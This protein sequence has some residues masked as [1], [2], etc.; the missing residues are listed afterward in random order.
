MK[1]WISFTMMM[2][3]VFV[4][5]LPAMAVENGQKTL[6]DVNAIYNAETNSV[7]A[8]ANLIYDDGDHVV[9]Y[10]NFGTAPITFYDEDGVV[11]YGAAD[12]VSVSMY[13]SYWRAAGIYNPILVVEVDDSYKISYIETPQVSFNGA[14]GYYVQ[15]DVSNTKSSGASSTIQL[16]A[17]F[18]N[19]P[20]TITGNQIAWFE[21]GTLKTTSGL[22]GTFPN[23][24]STFAIS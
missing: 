2:A 11:A 14:L 1:R 16:T 21:S 7:G 18:A 3:M 8:V 4:M 19:L 13:I 20:T 17:G 10:A 24:W 23:Y 15:Y 22:T 12:A 5:M 6:D 9:Y